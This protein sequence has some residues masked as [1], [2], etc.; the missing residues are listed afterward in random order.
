ML[1]DGF[2]VLGRLIEPMHVAVQNSPHVAVFGSDEI[3]EGIEGKG[4]SV[5]ASD[6]VE[7]IAG[8]SRLRSE[9]I[10]IEAVVD[11]AYPSRILE[12]ASFRPTC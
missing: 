10:R 4:V 3:V 9:Q 7:R 6:D 8:K 5:Q 11:R 2:E 12:I 1:L